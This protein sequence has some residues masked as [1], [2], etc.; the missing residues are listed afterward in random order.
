MKTFYATG[1]NMLL[2]ESLGTI[3]D[4]HTHWLIARDITGIV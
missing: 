1:K 4:V 3:T 2:C